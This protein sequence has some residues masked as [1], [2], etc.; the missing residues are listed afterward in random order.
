MDC[1]FQYLSQFALQLFTVEATGNDG[2][3]AVNEQGVRDAAHSVELC[4]FACPVFQ[5]AHLRPS[6]TQLLNSLLP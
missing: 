4:A 2:P 3:F 1:L 6:D 5:V